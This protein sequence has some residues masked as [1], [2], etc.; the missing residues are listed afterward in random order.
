M[1]RHTMSTV[2]PRR[3]KESF[4]AV[5]WVLVASVLIVV[6]LGLIT[7]NSFESNGGFF[8]QQLIWTVVG[9][10]VFAVLS[11]CDF[12]F[13][14]RT[15]VVVFLYLGTVVALALLF[16]IGT[17]L[18]GAQSWYTIFGFSVQPV[19]FAKIV[20]IIV[21]AKYFTR[22]HIE[23]A[24]FRHILVS[25]AYAFVI[26]TLVFLQPDFGSA[27]IIAAIWL[28]MVLVAG[29][30]KQH[31]LIIFL[32][33]AIAFV[34]MWSFALEGYQ[35]QRITSFLHPF[36]DIQ[37]AGYN[38]YQSMVAVGSGQLLG[39]G[40]GYGTQSRLEFLPEYQTDFI[41]AAFTEEWGFLGAVFLF[42][43][44]GVMIW[45]IIVMS[46][47][48]ASNFETLYGLG[49]AVYF[50]AHIAIHIGM[51]IGVLPI[52]GTTIPFMSYGGTHLVA[53]FAAIGILTGMNRYA[54]TGMRRADDTDTIE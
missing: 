28:G 46:M 30:S 17:T 42:T 19:E 33:A 38:A 20:L 27:L 31:L 13:L 34:G 50:M 6:S 23:I 26:F 16:V 36:T 44:Y 48:G 1:L 5:D 25:G 7:M 32:V 11:L 12:R 37:G 52:T 21:L 41:F 39:K 53:E 9:L 54:R 2:I 10:G 40:V 15:G 45:R 4:A 47:Y 22:R 14:R 3:V 49:V 18:K 51:N 8:A 43:V 35:K 29:I 24:H